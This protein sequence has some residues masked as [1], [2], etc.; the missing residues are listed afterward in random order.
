MYVYVS[1][2]TYTSLQTLIP[3]LSKLYSSYP[4]VLCYIIN[5]TDISDIFPYCIWCVLSSFNK[6]IWYGMVPSL[7]FVGLAIWKIWRMICVNI[8]GL[9]DLDLWPFDLESHQ[10]WGTF[11]PNFGTLGLRVLQLFAM[12]ATDGRTKA[13]LIIARGC[14][15]AYGRG[16]ISSAS[17]NSREEKF[18]KFQLNCE[19][20]RLASLPIIDSCL[21]NNTL[22]LA[23]ERTIGNSFRFQ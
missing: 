11:L 5:R 8:N 1:L 18:E 9:G 13:T 22:K 3:K 21:P 17:I 15:L 4:I 7:K 10:R 19:K 6:R 16:I 12:Y 14:P 2:Y 23:T 20:Q